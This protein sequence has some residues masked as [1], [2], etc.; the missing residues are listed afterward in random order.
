MAIAVEPA[1][2][3]QVREASREIVRE[4]GFMKPHLAATP[5]PASAV[6][7]IVEIGRHGALP[8]SRLAELLR[9]EK[10]S[11]SRM[12]RK[13]VKAGEVRESASPDD[14]R[15]KLLTLTARGRRTLAAIDAYGSGQV[16]R[17]LAGLPG[18]QREAVRAGLQTYARALAG[19]GACTGAS[20][21]I[22]IAHG[23]RPGMIGRIV[24]MHGRFYARAA[25]FGPYFESKVAAG[26][27]EFCARA[28]SPRSRVWT[29]EQEGRIV[30]AV[31]ID[32]EDLGD[33]VA[34][35]RWFIVDDGVRGAGIGRRLL[36]EA[37]AFCDETGFAAIRLWTFR[38]LDAARRLYEAH[39]FMLVEEWT[40]NQWGEEVVE[41][42]FERTRP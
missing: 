42:L 33:N 12:V 6:H 7:A 32:G 9:L 31:A 15:V 16:V 3:D 39:G 5:H 11:V 19:P 25:G 30:G 17:A 21:A 24:D 1:L 36:D 10:S 29:A 41:Q 26:L 8:A 34:H 23:Y 13:L 20:Q 40:G 4:L 18:A 37:L 14:G 28:S 38:G 2:I 27:A 22:D 35:L